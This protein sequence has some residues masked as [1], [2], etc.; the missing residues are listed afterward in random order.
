M[1]A[2]GRFRGGAAAALAAAAG[3]ALAAAPAAAAPR[4]DV[5]VAGP[6]RV[7]AGPVA[8][9]AAARTVAVGRRRCAVAAGTPLAALLAVRPGPVRLRDFGACGARSADAGS[10]FVAAIGG[11]VNR[12][13]D[14]WVYKAGR[15]VGTTG[16]ADSSGPFGDGRRLRAGARVTWFY[17]RMR[18]GGCQRTLEISAPAR[19]AAGAAI[20]V[21]VRGYDDAGR[22]RPAAG[23]TVAAGAATAVTDA[24]GRAAVVAGAAGTLSIAASAPGLVPAFPVRVAITASGGAG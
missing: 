7:L 23:A 21:V 8:V 17:C 11:A 2:S 14:G 6:A 22:G 10:L 13:Q 19:A 4:V 15:R 3:A 24:A 16:A 12:G 1:I 5:L 9:A 20:P 18:A